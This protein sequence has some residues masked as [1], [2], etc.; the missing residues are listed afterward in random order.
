MEIK[1]SELLNIVQQLSKNIELNFPET[2]EVDKE[3]FY[4]EIPEEN[5][6]D[7]T[8]EPSNLTLGQLSD[9]WEMLMRLNTPESTPLSHDLKRLS[10]ILQI[11]YKRSHGAW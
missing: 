8:S 3:D 4:W 6:Y 1:T 7:P 5:L 2:I 10:S 11:I 9:D